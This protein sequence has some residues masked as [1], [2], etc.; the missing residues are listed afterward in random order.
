M[1]CPRQICPV[2]FKLTEA[3]SR[4]RLKYLDNILSQSN[5]VALS[6]PLPPSCNGTTF[7]WELGCPFATYPFKIHS[8]VSKYKP[9]YILLNID[10]SSSTIRIRSPSCATSSQSRSA[11][12]EPCRSAIALIEHVQDR[13][14]NLLPS[15]DPV[16]ISHEQWGK[17]VNDL[18][19]RLQQ[20]WLKRLDVVKA[21]S[22][23]QAHR[24][25]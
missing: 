17:K 11:P 20:E 3:A 18:K 19:K 4:S 16:L 8:S 22:R 24:S 2:I 10:G 9:D 14:R 25:T 21:L 15:A 23:L 5:P 12:C 13:V 7:F 1:W 6:A